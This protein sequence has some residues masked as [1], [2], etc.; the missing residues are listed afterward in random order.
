MFL[1]C[2]WSGF[3]VGLTNLRE[4]FWLMWSVALLQDGRVWKVDTSGIVQ[5]ISQSVKE[6]IHSTV[7][8]RLRDLSTDSL[9]H[10]EMSWVI[11]VR[12]TVKTSEVRPQLL[13]TSGSETVYTL[14]E[15]DRDGRR[16]TLEVATTMMWCLNDIEQSKR[17][18]LSITKMYFARGTTVGSCQYR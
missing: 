6:W 5:H 8:C 16:P 9:A 11:T 13:P 15:T 10:V 14:P 1:L 2:V 4:Y 12:Q 3:S 7:P 17:M 18:Q